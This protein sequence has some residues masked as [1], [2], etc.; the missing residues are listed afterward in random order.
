MAFKLSK[1]LV[2]YIGEH[3]V[4]YKLALLG[5]KAHKMPNVYDFDILTQGEVRI[6]V[7]TSRESSV[8][9]KTRKGTLYESKVWQFANHAIKMKCKS[10][11]VTQQYSNRNRNCDFYVLVCLNKEGKKVL[12]S[13]IIPKKKMT[14]AQQIQI[15]DG[16][17]SRKSR[18]E[19]FLNTWELLKKAEDL[20]RYTG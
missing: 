17:S 10:G 1:D 19:D 9:R 20:G 14:L 18:Y 11:V 16:S 3:Y 15:Y 6:E 4:L 5:V 7:K 13:Y 2:G 8:N 12:K